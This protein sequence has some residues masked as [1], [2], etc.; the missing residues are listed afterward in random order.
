MVQSN[1]MQYR[2][3][4]PTEW[5]SLPG[6]RWT[7]HVRIILTNHWLPELILDLDIKQP[8]SANAPR[9]T[10][11]QQDP[12]VDVVVS[13][14]SRPLWRRSARR[15]VVTHQPL[16]PA[17]KFPLFAR[18]RNSDCTK[19]YKY[20]CTW[21]RKDMH[22]GPTDTSAVLSIPCSCRRWGREKL[23]TALR[24]ISCDSFRGRIW[25]VFAFFVTQHLMV[26]QSFAFCCKY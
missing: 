19:W 23:S 1:G 24:I 17:E 26:Q 10:Q 7:D 14:Y 8:H 16:T 15:T 18:R 11:I 21:T 22:I 12:V 2:I 13:E 20:N 25:K 6:F 3:W 5:P 9:S 4:I